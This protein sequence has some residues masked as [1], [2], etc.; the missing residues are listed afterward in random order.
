MPKHQRPMFAFLCSVVLSACAVEQPEP[1]ETEQPKERVAP[2]AMSQA[3]EAAFIAERLPPELFGDPKLS[4]DDKTQQSIDK[5]LKQLQAAGESDTLVAD[6]EAVA[7]AWSKLGEAAVA[8]FSVSKP[9]CWKNGCVV[10]T[11]HSGRESLDA[12]L[13]DLTHTKGFNRWNAGKFRSGVQELSNGEVEVT[14]VFHAPAE[15][16]PVMQPEQPDDDYEE[17]RMGL[18]QSED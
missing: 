11:K 14:W 12:I 16:Q 10:V 13:T 4:Q 18:G 3:E 1:T 5:Q 15:G 6:A 9:Q 7:Q 8:K 2:K 17:T